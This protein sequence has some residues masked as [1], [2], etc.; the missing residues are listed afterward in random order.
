[1]NTKPKLPIKFYREPWGYEARLGGNL[2]G[3]VDFDGEDWYAHCKEDG[4]WCHMEPFRTR[5]GAAESL[6]AP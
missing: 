2:L 3:W 5:Q 4:C 1:M 6:V